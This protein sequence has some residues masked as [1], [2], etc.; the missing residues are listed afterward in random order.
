MASAL[1]GLSPQQTNR[2]GTLLRLIVRV[3]RCRPCRLILIVTGINVRVDVTGAIQAIIPK[4]HMGTF[5]EVPLTNATA[6]LVQR[7]GG[8]GGDGYSLPSFPLTFHYASRHVDQLLLRGLL[9]ERKFDEP[10]CPLVIPVKNGQQ[11]RAQS[12]VETSAGAPPAPWLDNIK[13]SWLVVAFVL[14]ATELW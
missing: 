7:L 3:S 11:S 14:M 5:S 4:G 2:Y 6:T 9:L 10:V 12:V 8:W 1:V 13:C